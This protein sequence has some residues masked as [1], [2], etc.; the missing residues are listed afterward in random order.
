MLQSYLCGFRW[1]SDWVLTNHAISYKFGYV[2]R[3]LVGEVGWLIFRDN[4]Y[5]WKYMSVVIM[6]VSAVFMVWTIFI[7][8]RSEYS[9]SNAV[10][11]V[12]MAAFAI[13]PAAR[14]YLHEMG[15]YEQYGYLLIIVVFFIC[16]KYGKWSTYLLPAIM[17]LLAIFISESNAFLVVP[18]IFAYSFITIADM[19]FDKKNKIRCC[20]ILFATYIPHLIYCLFVWLYR[21]PEQTVLCLQ[22]HDRMSVNSLFEYPNFNFREDAHLFLSAGRSKQVNGEMWQIRPH[23]MHIW[24]LSLILM[25]SLLIIYVMCVENMKRERIISYILADTIVVGMAYSICLIAWDLERFYFNA[26]MSAFLL[27]VFVAK[28]Y[29]DGIKTTS[30]MLLVFAIVMVAAIGMSK[31]RFGL[32][33][34]A[35]YNEMLVQFIDSWNAKSLL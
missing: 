22:E 28:K 33:D 9:Y 6:T 23:R 4:W 2:P 18:V 30:S 5:S 26:Y 27:S 12:L 35:R 10:L 11:M 17:G 14:Y 1:P 16:K 32:F 20:F 24:C 34:D 7:I 21:V 13:S 29:F 31:N 25:I 15:Y 8:F 3:G 19:D